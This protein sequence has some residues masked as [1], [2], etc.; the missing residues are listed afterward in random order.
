MLSYLNVVLNVVTEKSKASL[1][2]S[3]LCALRFCKRCVCQFPSGLPMPLFVMLVE[4]WSFLW[5]WSTF[6]CVWQIVFSLC[7]GMWCY[8]ALLWMKFPFLVLFVFILLNFKEWST[9]FFFS[10]SRHGSL[11]IYSANYI[12]GEVKSGTSIFH[13]V[14]TYKV[15]KVQY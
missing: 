15:Y 4:F 7:T 6:H 8:L 3:L 11:D 1:I 13:S 14:N 5:I 9:P 10:R 2:F 12:V